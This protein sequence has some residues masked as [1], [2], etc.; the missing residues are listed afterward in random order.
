MFPLPGEALHP[1]AFPAFSAETDLYLE[2]EDK[3]VVV[4]LH[5]EIH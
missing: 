5:L 4:S 2:A 1:V 3:L